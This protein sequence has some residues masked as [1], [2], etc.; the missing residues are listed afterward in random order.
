MERWASMSS[1]RSI[2][3]KRNLMHRVCSMLMHI[4]T[5]AT[6]VSHEKSQESTVKYNTGYVGFISSC[7]DPH[8]TRSVGRRKD[9]IHKKDFHTI[10]AEMT[11]SYNE[12]V[13]CLL[14]CTQACLQQ[15]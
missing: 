8:K 11:D 2:P 6:E 3:G 9:M 7:S 14:K 1:S 5:Q 15:S 4:D 10:Q 13:S 12:A